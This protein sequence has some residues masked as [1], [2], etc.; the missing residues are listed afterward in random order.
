M[1][2]FPSRFVPLTDFIAR[3]AQWYP[4][5]AAIF[6]AGAELTWSAFNRRI[7]RLANRL[8]QTGISKGD[9]VAVISPNC[10]EYPEI[11]F[12]ILKS[13]GVAV[14]VSSMLKK[15]T[16]LLELKDA[17]AKVVI[18]AYPF[19]D[20]LNDASAAGLKSNWILLSGE[21][22][23]WVSYPDFC[24]TGSESEPKIVHAADDVY[25]IVYSSGTTGVPK[26]IVHTHQARVLFALTCGLEFRIHNETVALITTPIYTNGT[27]LI[28]L[29][30]ILIGGTLVIMPSFSPADLLNLIQVRKCTHV[31][32][33]PTQF[34]RTMDHP[35]FGRYDTSSVEMLLS[36]AA[37]LRQ[38]TKS[39]ILQKFPK[40]KLAELYGITEGISTVLR[41]NEQFFKPGSVGKPRLGGDIKI[42]DDYG[43][44]LPP[45]EAGEIVGFSFSMMKEYF[46]SPQT[47]EGVVWHD[48]E[49][50]I[51]IRTGDIGKLDSEGYLY[52]LD[53]KK[54]MIVSGGINIYPSDIE[55]VLLKHP[56]V[57]EAAV[58]GIPHREWGES[59]IALVIKK[60]PESE[61]SEETLSE[62]V[63]SK[64][65]SYQKLAALEFRQSFPR[66]DLGKIL[67]NELRRPYWP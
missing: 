65:A 43:K 38:N 47:T 28:F 35:E 62:W 33:T 48:E 11:L 64:L 1:T 17:G 6:C 44:E 42:V 58:I 67:K 45:G 3:N 63:N 37:P 4:D 61:T 13:G 19:S 49:G 30:T 39:E 8:I 10:L 31:F 50:R 23:G 5:K 22:E 29:P 25:N 40:S 15:E 51:Y 36:A 66:N 55:D 26:G 52:I 41:P 12:G 53:R 2:S 20:I 18:A 14:P 16:I 27:Q 59:P 7:N 46:N 54:D 24:R 21:A 57:E 60:D 32:M 34:I 9:K 56:E